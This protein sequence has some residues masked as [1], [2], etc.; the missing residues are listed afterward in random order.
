[1]DGYY[2]LALCILYPNYICKEK[3]E[4][5]YENAGKTKEEKRRG[6][7]SGVGRGTRWITDEIRQEMLNLRN[8]I[9]LKATADLYGMRDSDL[10]HLLKKYKKKRGIP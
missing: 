10:C 5:I 7:C 9:G 2:I 1:M 4:F 8:E 6:S 3:A